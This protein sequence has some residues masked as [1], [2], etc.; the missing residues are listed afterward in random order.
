MV[1]F[2]NAETQ[3]Q[4]VSLCLCD[5]F[6]VFTI[7]SFLAVL[8]K[9]GGPPGHELPLDG[10]PAPRA[11]LSRFAVDPEF[12]LE[13]SGL[14]ALAF[15]IDYGGT[16]PVNGPL[17]DD[18]ALADDFLPL[19]PGKRTSGGSRVDTAGKQD[20]VHIN[21]A[22]P[23]HDGVIHEKIFYRFAF[24]PGLALQVSRGNLLPKGFPA[25][26]GKRVRFR[27]FVRAQNFN[28]T[29]TTHIIEPEFLAVIELKTEMVMGAGR[30]APAENAKLA[31]HAQVKD[32]QTS[33]I[34]TDQQISG[35]PF[36]RRDQ[37]A[38]QLVLNFLHRHGLPQLFPAAAVM[39]NPAAHQGSDQGLPHN[40]DL[41][42]FRHDVWR[43]LLLL[44][45]W[46]M[47]GTDDLPAFSA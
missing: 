6:L 16:S 43:C 42:E 21:I 33:I 14:A 17:Q 44:L 47:I 28:K 31:G 29:E 4:F 5:I 13:I 35:P 3:S 7:P 32:Q 19:P 15:K 11:G 27:R 41:R 39:K 1:I 34:Q 8:T 22:Y 12:K 38:Y 10:R 23:Y 46:E 30:V 36:D 37:G 18:P 40:F 26:A 9:K 45:G 25:Q 2:F 24:A 20:L